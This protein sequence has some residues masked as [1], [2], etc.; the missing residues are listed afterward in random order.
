MGAA[1]FAHGIN[2]TKERSLMCG[3]AGTINLELSND[4]L[5]KIAHRGPDASKIERIKT[6]KEEVWFGHVRLSIQDLTENGS[7][8]MKSPS[9]NWIVF[10]GEVYNHLELRERYLKDYDFLGHSDTE[11][12]L[13]LIETFGVSMAKEFNG[14]FAFAYYDNVLDEVVLARDRYGVKPLYYYISDDHF[15]FSSEIRL[16][17]QKIDV[18]LSEPFISTPLLMRFSPA[19]DTIYK[20]VKKVRPGEI[21][22]YSC[23]TGEVVHSSIE[24]QTGPQRDEPK[25][26]KY[27]IEKAVKSQLLSDVEIGVFLSGGID[28][29]VV[30]K[31]AQENLNYK[32]KAY[33]VGFDG[34]D[35]SELAYARESASL[36]NLDFVPIVINF[37]DFLKVFEECVNI[38]EEPLG[39]DS[40][41]PMYFLAREA[42]RDVKVVLTGQGA[43]EPLAGYTRYKSELLRH[44]IPKFTSNIASIFLSKTRYGRILKEDDVIKRYKIYHMIFEDAEVQVLLNSQDFVSR[45]SIILNDLNVQR[46]GGVND[47]IHLDLVNNLSDDLLLYT[48][49]ITMHFGLECRV[50]MLDNELVRHVMSLDIDD[51]LGLFSTKK[52]HRKYARSFLPESIINRKKLGFESPTDTWFQEHNSVLVELVRNEGGRFEEI[53]NKSAV[54]ELLRQHAI[55]PSFRKKVFLVLSYL[56]LLRSISE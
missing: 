51:R 34:S 36:L 55:T 8:P 4:D 32:V 40:M 28:S 2:R 19:P 50:P 52:V 43:D 26:Y 3:I 14:I 25:S 12:I 5:T 54:I 42:S 37:D 29:A 17:R 44:S 11:T 1:A 45:D 13:I 47:L 20:E 33:S 9:G 7:Q 46:S 41:I 35:V 15:V 21:I 31:I 53:F 18:E 16:I 56:F 30:A 49:K 27:F 23:S 24:F 48:D 22:S 6:G 38:V 10:N 39:T